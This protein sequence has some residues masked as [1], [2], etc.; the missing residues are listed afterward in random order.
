MIAPAAGGPIAE[1]EPRA[2]VEHAEQGAEALDAEALGDHRRGECDEAAVADAEHDREQQQ[3]RVAASGHPPQHEAQGH[4]EE[5]ALEHAQQPER[6]GERA[7]RDP[8]GHAR[9]ADRP[10]QPGREHGVDAAVLGVGRQ[11]DEGHEE[12]HAHQRRREVEPAVLAV[13]HRRAQRRGARARGGRRRR[14]GERAQAQRRDADRGQHEVRVPPPD[15]LD[16]RGRRGRD[17]QRADADAG[18]RDA[19]RERP[20]ALE[21]RAD[22]RDH[23]YVG[24]G[25]ADPDPEAV[26]GERHPE[27]A[28][29]RGRDEAEPERRRADQQHA[30]LAEAVARRAADA[31]EPE[32]QQRG[33][34][35][36][37]RPG[38]AA[39]AEVG[40]HLLEERAVAVG[41]PEGDEH[42]RERRGDDAPGARRVKAPPH[43]RPPYSPDPL[44]QT[45]PPA[46]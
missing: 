30:P 23:R 27:R 38:R 5:A 10:D 37:R 40:A 12:R 44:S 21:P 19:E 34:R 7:E 24:A 45:M 33:Q 20:P 11:V 4:R 13:A 3:H 8:A 43:P 1:P 15:R 16:Q 18:H 32:V 2:G 9:G 46:R 6:P 29:A 36:E 14:R 17:H 26:R 35:E 42:R 41:D 28:G 25:D 39:D 22:E 31:A